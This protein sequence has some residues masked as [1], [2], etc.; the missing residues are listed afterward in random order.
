MLALSVFSAC[1]EYAAKGHD[2]VHSP[3]VPFEAPFCSSFERRK[4]WVFLPF[5]KCV[6]AW[7]GIDFQPSPPPDEMI[8][9]MAERLAGVGEAQ[10]SLIY[11]LCFSI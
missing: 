4:A 11:W 2:T 9:E 3:H 7:K 10:A 5:L 1:L 8:T 6:T